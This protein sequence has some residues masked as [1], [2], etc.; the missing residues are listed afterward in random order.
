MADPS[1]AIG[2]PSL[3][4]R[5]LLFLLVPMLTLL[6]A[7]AVVT[8][9]VALGYANRV[10]DN[11]LSND[12]RTLA[13]M[14]RSERIAG[15]LPEEARFLL[16]NDPSGHNYYT[17]RSTRRGLLSGNGAFPQ[18]KVPPSDERPRL[19]N[20]SIDGKP[21]RAAALSLSSNGDPQEV[22]TVTIAENLRDRHNQARQILL[23]TVPLQS[24][25]ILGMMSLVWLGV[26]R[27][28]RILQPLTDRLAAREHELAPIS[29]ADVPREILPLTRTIDA[30]FERLRAVLLL[31]ERFIADAA[32]QLR[33]PLAGLQLHVEKALADPSPETVKDALNHIHLLTKRTARTSNQLLALM[34]AQSPWQDKS[35][36]VPVDLGKV[37]PDWIGYRIHDALKKGIDL[38]YQGPG[39]AAV[40]LGDAETLHELLDNLID[41]A[42]RYAGHGARV[43]VSVS[44]LLHEGILLQVEDN[45]PGVAAEMASRL[46]ERFFRA[47][48]SGE[49]GT[50][51]GLAI[52]QQIAARHQAIVA[53]GAAAPRGLRITLQFPA[54]T[55]IS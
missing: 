5:L 44:H 10:H 19:F 51:L 7:D 13:Q 20:S 39:N 42:L 55:G 34:R 47:P 23:L 17:V 29:A 40:V 50:G 32:H 6:V 3:R 53:F 52:V 4:R 26:T 38:G 48:G 25:L 46:G 37:I 22:L 9:L 33:T 24:L 35:M 31:Q 11:D 1:R 27:G 54:P 15:D 2:S 49:G 36:F 30:L 45:G 28:L 18:P 16:E 21:L 12:V 14:Y 41:N 8:Y 43:T